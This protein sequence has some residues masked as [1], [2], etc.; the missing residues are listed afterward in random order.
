[1]TAVQIQAP[2]LALDPATRSTLLQS[3]VDTLPHIPNAS[4]A[5]RAARR[6]GAFAIVA[7][8]DPRDPV[9]AMFVIHIIA[10]H[11]ACVHNYR[12]AALPDV[13]PALHLRYQARAAAMSRL[14][15]ARMREFNRLQAEAARLAKAAVAVAGPRAPQASAVAVGAVVRQVAPVARPESADGGSLPGGVEAGNSTNGGEVRAGDAAI[16]H[17]LAEVAARLAAADVAL[18]A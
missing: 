8:L 16:D 12:C 4:E 9:Q 3:I 17:L 7:Q 10:A 11:Y 6:E 2:P 14:S 13:T 1:M 18:A 5:E 15:V